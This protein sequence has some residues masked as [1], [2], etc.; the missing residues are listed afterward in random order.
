MLQSKSKFSMAHPYVLQ[1]DFCDESKLLL[2]AHLLAETT[3]QTIRI[4]P[5][6][7]FE[8]RI[9]LFSFSWI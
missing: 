1:P 7:C 4:I 3:K 6:S 2:F 8:R 9:I 5:C